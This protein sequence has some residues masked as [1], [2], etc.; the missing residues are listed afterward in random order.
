MIPGMIGTSMPAARAAGTKSK[1]RLLSKKSWVIRK[2]APAS[3][4]VFR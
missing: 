2:L 3:T 4:L 1:Y